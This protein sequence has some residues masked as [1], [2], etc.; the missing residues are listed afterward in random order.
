MADFLPLFGYRPDRDGTDHFLASLAKPTLS[1]A[2]PDLV[3]DE[4]RDVFLGSALLRCDANWKRGA[5]KIGS[6]VG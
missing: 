5:Q 2:G 6:C 1:Q 4:T 3:L